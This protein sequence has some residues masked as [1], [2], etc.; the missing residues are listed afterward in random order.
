MSA[1]LYYTKLQCKLSIRNKDV[2][3]TYYIVPLLF[4]IFMGGIF[5][6]ILEN[7]KDILI[8][9]MVI[10]SITMGGVL[11]A[12]SICSEL[13]QKDVR[14]AYQIGNI[15]IWIPVSVNFITGCIHLLLMVIIILVTAPIL[16]QA[17][18]PP[19]FQIFTITIIIYIITCMLIGTT[20]GLYIHDHA[21]LTMA[22]QLVFLPSIMLS[23][24]MFP[25]SMLPKFLYYIGKIFPATW[26]Q[27]LLTGSSS[28]L[29]L[30][31]VL[32]ICL[33]LFILSIHRLRILQT[34]E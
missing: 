11:G 27:E 7:G 2:F 34:K 6:S 16:F 18:Y 26:C 1:F 20:Y 15:P 24:I 8:S 29:N 30:L 9:M 33:T 31:P 25:S 13:Y 14:K 10:F 32:V 21:K 28:Y 12:P 5:S 23:G 19:S 3:V 17:S 22:S 4:Y